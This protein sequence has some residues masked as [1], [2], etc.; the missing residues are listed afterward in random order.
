M[1]ADELR[2]ILDGYFAWREA[3]AERKH[4]PIMRRILT[5]ENRLLDD[6][7]VPALI[8]YLASIGIILP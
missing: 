6:V 7:G 1:S 2:K 5:I 4:R 8:L 3:Q